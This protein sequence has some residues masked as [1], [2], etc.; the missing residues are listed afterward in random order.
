[1]QI[2]GLPSTSGR[3]RSASPRLDL[4]LAL[5]L[6]YKYQNGVCQSKIK[7]EVGKICEQEIYVIESPVSGDQANK[8]TGYREDQAYLSHKP[9]VR[10]VRH[11]ES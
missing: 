6:S 2:P 9:V 1:M 3:I 11:F 10:T 7:Y 5:G 8:G 4:V